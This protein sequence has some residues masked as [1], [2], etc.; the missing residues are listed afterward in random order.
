MLGSRY[1]MRN[2]RWNRVPTKKGRAVL[3]RAQQTS[4]L[5]ARACVIDNAAEAHNKIFPGQKPSLTPRQACMALTQ[6]KVRP[7]LLIFF[8]ASPY[9]LKLVPYSHFDRVFRIGIA[10]PQTIKT[11]DLRIRSIQSD[12]RARSRWQGTDFMR[13]A[14]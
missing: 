5:N 13:L 14:C 10:K 9:Q 6:D 3:A 7:P 1:R 2:A 12:F 11:A 4:D 8:A